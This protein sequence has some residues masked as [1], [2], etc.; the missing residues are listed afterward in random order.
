MSK[1]YMNLVS[2]NNE[3]ISPGSPFGYNE[4]E[5]LSKGGSENMNKK[6]VT[7]DELKISQLETQNRLIQLDNKIDTKF[8]ELNSKIDRLND[9]FDD[10]FSQI[11][12]IIENALYK[13]R[14]YQQNQQKENRRFFWGTI[15]IGGISAAAAIISIAVT[16]LH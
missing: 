16:L 5:N 15:I 7:H 2:K 6:F 4:D 13:E 12:M 1:D 10:K 3:S 11:P 14:E 8:N 9:K